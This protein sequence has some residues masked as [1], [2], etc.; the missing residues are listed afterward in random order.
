MINKFDELINAVRNTNSNVDEHREQHKCL[1]NAIKENKTNI[2]LVDDELHSN[3]PTKKGLVY[4]ITEVQQAV[5]DIKKIMNIGL[6][7]CIA[8]QTLPFLQNIIK[9]LN[10]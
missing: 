7:V 8:L 1:W 4:Q 10:K 9:I 3:I 2:A 6:G 5:I